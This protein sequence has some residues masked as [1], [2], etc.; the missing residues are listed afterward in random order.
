MKPLIITLMLLAIAG[1]GFTPSGTAVRG[2]VKTYSAQAFDE[3]LKNAEYYICKV[4]SIG[5]V[6]R[7]Y[8]R[9]QDTA[10]AWKMLCKGDISVD[11]IIPESPL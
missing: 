4:A 5:A 3:G 1:C 2:A 9:S 10:D 7:R 11:I 8:G 6:S